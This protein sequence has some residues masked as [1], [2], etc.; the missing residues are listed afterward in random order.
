M[1]HQCHSGMEDDKNINDV[2]GKSK[3]NFIL[4]NS[5]SVFKIWFFSTKDSQFS[6]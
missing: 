2:E 6:T 1:L 5:N 4:L 3:V